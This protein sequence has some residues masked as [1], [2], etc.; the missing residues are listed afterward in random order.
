MKRI[1]ENKIDIH[2]KEIIDEYKLTEIATEDGWV[3]IA[4]SR[5]M[6]GLPQSGIIAQEQLEKRLVKH[7]YSQSKIIPGY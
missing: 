7:G 4:V 5:G 1:H 3:Y 6:C 2:S